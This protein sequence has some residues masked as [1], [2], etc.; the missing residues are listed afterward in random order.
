MLVEN[1]RYLLQ[2]LRYI[3]RNPLRA[4]LAEK[5]DDYN[6]SSHK[7]YITTGE[8]WNWLHKAFILSMFTE[9]KKQ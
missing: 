4:G 9:D 5:L 2:V 6:W 1:G 7:G 3:H 8:K